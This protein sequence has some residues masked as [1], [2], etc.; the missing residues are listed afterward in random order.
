MVYFQTWDSYQTRD[1][2]I[3]GSQNTYFAYMDTATLWKNCTDCIYAGARL[4]A[5]TSDNLSYRTPRYYHNDALGSVRLMT[6]DDTTVFYR[7]GYQPYYQ[8]NGKPY[9]PS[10]HTNPQL[11]FAGKPVSAKQQVRT[12]I[13]PVSANI[14]KRL[15]YHCK[16]ISRWL[17]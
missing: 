3:E 15:V 1:N 6:K 11:K 4:V 17:W 9:C 10:C 2:R 16:P 13:S 8:D 5:F 14:F 12:V 7:D